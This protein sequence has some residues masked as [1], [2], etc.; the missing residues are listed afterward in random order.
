M[1][2]IEEILVSAE[3]FDR[4]FVCHL[5]KCK[6]ACCWEGDFGAPVAEHEE[7]PMIAALEEVVSYLLP[8]NQKRIEDEGPFQFNQEYGGKVTTLMDDGSCA[9]LFKNDAGHAC[10]SFE[11]AFNDGKSEFQKPIS[12][13]LYPLRVKKNALSGFEAINYDDWEI[14]SAACQLGTELNIPVFRFVRQALER[15]YGQN[16]YDQLEAVY[17][18]IISRAGDQ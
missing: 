11:Q 10:C 6:G 13:H 8:T 1:Y 5:D 17:E 9:F 16:F 3:V 4:K 7:Q 14:C 2:L 18:D 15:A 12:C